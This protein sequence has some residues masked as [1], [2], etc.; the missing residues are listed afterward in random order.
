MAAM[1]HVEG[2]ISAV[3]TSFGYRPVQT[4]T[5]ELVELFELKSGADI[6]QHLYVFEDK[7]GRRLCLRPEATA[8]VA[9]MYAS[10]LRSSP[11][12]LRLSYC[13]PMFRYE[14]PQKGRYREFWQ[15]GVELFGASGSVA[16]AEVVCL[17]SECLK[18]LGLDFTLRVSHMG[19][20]RALLDGLG[21]EGG[22][23]D[24][25]LQ[26]LDRGDLKAVEEK[27]GEGS[28]TRLLKLKGSA[29]AV[30]SALKLTS[31]GA[32]KGMLAEFKATLALLDSADVEYAVDFSMS[33][34]LDYYTGLV[35]DVRAEGLGAQNQI[36]GGGRYDRLVALF[37]GPETPAVGFAFGLDRTIEALGHQG[38]GLP[39]P[40]TD[41]FVVPAS[42]EVRGDAFRIALEMRRKLVGLTVDLELTGRKLNR[43]L[44]HASNVKARYAV[45]V[46]AKEL[47]EG[48]VVLRDMSSQSQSTVRIQDLASKIV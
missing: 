30:D 41:V 24:S 12:P 14:E 5:F 42:D 13:G 17:A 39:S 7:G 16:D 46:G 23:Q 34:G 4:P 18:R 33:R 2:V 20:L 8:S 22:G 25:I 38:V 10:D 21:F 40:K 11:K 32:V 31:D 44:Q 29:D 6:K 26:L 9:R 45:I 3:F 28:F 19:V 37:G 35:F 43:A 15:A 48:S 1:A 27:V 36:C 47:G